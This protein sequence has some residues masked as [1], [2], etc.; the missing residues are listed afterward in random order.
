MDEANARLEALYAK[1]GR[2]SKYRTKAERDRFLNDEIVSIE[3]YITS[4][5]TTLQTTQSELVS[6]RTS[7]SEVNQQISNV[8]SKIEDGRKRV[9]DLNLEMS[10]L[11]IERN[12]HVEKRK[13]MWREDSKVESLLG[14]AGDELRT[15]ERALAGMMDKDTGMGLKA[16]DKIVEQHGIEGVYGPLYR[17]FE[18]E[19]HKFNVA[20]ELTAGNS[21]ALFS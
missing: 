15:A 16:I 9:G 2:A 11:D 19:D 10:Q 18:I 14:R 21:Y 17:L 3:S 12:E 8:S 6:A 20:V 4:Q 5:N 1:Q 13:E 7:L